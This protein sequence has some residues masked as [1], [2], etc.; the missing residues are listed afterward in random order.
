MQQVNICVAI[1]LFIF[2][3]ILFV[4]TKFS[5]LFKV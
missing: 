3:Q 4:Y 2:H 1:F 5:F